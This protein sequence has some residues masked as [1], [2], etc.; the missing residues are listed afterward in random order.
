MVIKVQ[1]RDG[2]PQSSSGIVRDGPPSG[3]PRRRRRRSGR[4]SWSCAELRRH[5]ALPPS[6]AAVGIA[7]GR[8]NTHL[9]STCHNRSRQQQIVSF[10]QLFSN[11]VSPRIARCLRLHGWGILGH[12]AVIPGRR[13]GAWA[14]RKYSRI[15]RRTP[16]AR[17]ANRIRGTGSL[18]VPTETHTR[19]I[20]A[21]RP[22]FVL[23]QNT[24]ASI[25]S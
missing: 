17:L 18:R 10:L 6:L 19:P 5:L 11:S 20:R 16:P 12:P 8:L 3:P 9:M 21:V 1:S 4:W 13:R 22:V 24:S 2:G 14:P 15:C 25:G 7:H 23:G